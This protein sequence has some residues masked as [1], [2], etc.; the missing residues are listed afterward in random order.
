M[1]ISSSLLAQNPSDGCAGVPAIVVGNCINSFDLPA[2]Y[3]DGGFDSPC[4]T[5]GQ[6][7][8][9]GWY[10]FTATSVVTDIDFTGG[11]RAVDVAVMTACSGGTQIGCQLESANVDF[12]FS[13]PT[14]IGVTYFIQIHR[15]SG[16][17]G[18]HSLLGAGICLSEGTPPPANNDICS[19]TVLPT[20]T[21]CVNSVGTNAGATDSGIANPG[22][23]YSGGD[24]WWSVL[25]PAAGSVVITASDIG[26]FTD[27]ALSVYTGACGAPVL[28][29]CIG[30]GNGLMPSV[31]VTAP[32]GDVIFVRFWEEGNDSEGTYGICAIEP[33]PPATNDE[34]GTATVTPVNAFGDG[35]AS[36]V[37]GT[38]TGATATAGL[39]TACAGSE[40][41]DVWFEFVAT[42]TGV[43]MSLLNIV[44]STSDM[45][46]SLWTGACPGLAFVGGSCSDPESMSMDGL[47]I[48]QTYFLRV[49]SYTAITGQTSSFDVCISET[50]I[51]GGTG[52]NDYCFTPATLTKE[53][54][55]F[56]ATTAATFTQDEPGNVDLLFC[57]SIE[58]NS[59][60]Q[61]TAT[62]ATEDFPVTS[63]TG[64]TSGIQAE[65]YE[66]VYDGSGCC[67]GFTSVS[68]CYSPGTTA[69]GTVSATGL[70]IGND[71][72]LMV[73]GFGGSNCTFSVSNWTGINILPV[74]ITGFYGS[75]KTEINE[76]NWTTASE[77]NNSH[78]IIEKSIDGINYNQ[79]GKVAGS[80]N[81]SEQNKY[82]F[83]DRDNQNGIVYYK[84]KQVDFDGTT[85]T[86][87]N[88]KMTREVNEISIYPNPTENNLSFSLTKI[89]SEYITIEYINTQGKVVYEVIDLK[90]RTSFDSNIFESLDKG[91]YFVKII[92]EKNNI[93]KTDK[94]IK[95]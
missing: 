17:A 1:L 12:A 11:D 44:G 74:S 8:D 58:N 63:V 35:C 24:T 16:N 18:S 20:N 50:D 42:S 68:N 57:G 15:V 33:P 14:T 93:I 79:I 32:A 86:I 88:I 62:S 7:R 34:C 38:V 85:K 4:R 80:G 19:A 46:M 21:T 52:T 81:S 91:M 13:V 25:M 83:S 61:F 5:A 71:Y 75:T 43:N 26:G 65:V 28:L 64:C 37:S 69:L 23:G 89:D 92:D 2:S 40:D 41:D 3:T 10:Q 90:D 94:I 45:A 39:S 70:T 6:N 29:G 51:C 66:I 9:D 82:Y 22:C 72:M 73:D 59:W 87:G 36:T 49:F 55:T 78:Y 54:G 84:L 77:I 27:G 30:T 76:L 53:A 31:Q 56:S 48:G 95:L 67:N 47:T 60:Y